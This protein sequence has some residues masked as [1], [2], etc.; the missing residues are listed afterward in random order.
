MSRS[1][2]V[3]GSYLSPYV[4]KVL[5]SLEIKGLSYEIDP[6]VPFFGN[7]RFRELSPLQRIPVLIDGD[8][9]LCDSSVICQYLEEKYP[10][11]PIYPLGIEDRAKARW[12]EEFSDSR[13]GD[14]IIWNLYNE[15]VIK[16]FVW[17]I[18]PNEAVI[19][20]ALKEDIPL[21][22]DYLE[23][24]IPPTNFLYKTSTTNESSLSIADISIASMFRNASFA[25]YV[26]D[27][28]RWPKTFSYIERVLSHDSFQRL[29]PFETLCLRTPINKQ[30]QALAEI[31][32][33]LTKETLGTNKPTKGVMT[34]L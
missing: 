30:R 12:L 17:N 6:I 5:V 15:S 23:N 3:I 27:S 8:L 9:S 28:T 14:V 7:N 20:K 21:I 11:P 32:A 16:K 1:V 25:K 22:L 2:K 24:Q 33:P 31:G 26:I 18:Q 4:R 13:M 10:T 19:E 29:K 34:R